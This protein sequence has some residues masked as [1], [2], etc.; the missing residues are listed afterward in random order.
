MKSIIYSITSN[1]LISRFLEEE[2]EEEPYEVIP[3]LQVP[4][5]VNL[6]NK[7]FKS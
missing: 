6:V 4:K 7:V 5:G 3:E 1:C 2:E